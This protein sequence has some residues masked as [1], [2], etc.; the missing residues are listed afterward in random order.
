MG[1]YSDYTTV[2]NKAKAAL[3]KVGRS[4]TFSNSPSQGSKM[5]PVALTELMNAIDYAHN[6]MTSGSS[7]TG[8]SS[9]HSY[10]ACDSN[11]TTRYD[12]AKSSVQWSDY[13]HMSY[14]NG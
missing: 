13:Q 2:L 1:T 14:G 3:S 12:G 7:S 4:Y 6:G 11:Y 9:N 8:C 10:T 5:Y